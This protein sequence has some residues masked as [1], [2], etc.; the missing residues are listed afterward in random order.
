MESPVARTVLPI[1]AS[2]VR[3]VGFGGIKKVKSSFF[4]EEQQVSLVKNR[5]QA[6]ARAQAS[7]AGPSLWAG[8]WCLLFSSPVASGER[9]SGIGVSARSQTFAAG[10]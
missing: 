2:A 8:H 3:Q 5:L 1:R 10:I 7:E 6:A 9:G 4:Q